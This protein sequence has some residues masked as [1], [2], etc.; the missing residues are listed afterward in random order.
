MRSPSAELLAV[1]RKRSPEIW[2]T[3][4]PITALLCT[5][6]SAAILF[7]ERERKRERESMC[8]VKTVDPSKRLQHRAQITLHYTNTWCS[9]KCFI[10]YLCI[11]TVLDIWTLNKCI[12]IIVII[13][14]LVISSPYRKHFFKISQKFWSECF[15]IS[16]KYW[17]IISSVLHAGVMWM[18]G[19]FW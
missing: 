18:S 2:L 5:M 13:I 11:G 9:V 16:R 15:R 14:Q 17:R 4:A 7:R 1:R 6:N 12:I 8:D 19:W 3:F 10:E